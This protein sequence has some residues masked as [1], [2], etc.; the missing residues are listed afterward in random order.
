[1]EICD[2]PDYIPLDKH[3]SPLLQKSNIFKVLHCPYIKLVFN[4]IQPNTLISFYILLF[5]VLYLQ[6]VSASLKPSS[7]S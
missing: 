2:T 7:E 5:T 4:R 1:M 6:H 3:I